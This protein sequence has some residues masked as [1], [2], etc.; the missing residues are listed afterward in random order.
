MFVLSKQ[1][2]GVMKESVVSTFQA[3]STNQNYPFSRVS[4]IIGVNNES[5]PK[6]MVATSHFPTLLRGRWDVV[7]AATPKEILRGAQVL[8]CVPRLCGSRQK[9]T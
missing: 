3:T 8:C 4:M 2:S 7:R 9:E 6:K 1:L 5:L